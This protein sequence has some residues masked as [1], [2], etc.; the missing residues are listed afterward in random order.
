VF[1]WAEAEAALGAA[2]E[3]GAIAALD[4]PG[5]D[6]I[7]DIHGGGEYRAHLVKVMA[8]RAVTAAR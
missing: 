3:A 1:R 6:M 8:G 7:S 4:P 2:F 5:C